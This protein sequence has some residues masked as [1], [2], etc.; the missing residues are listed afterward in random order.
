MRPLTIRATVSA[1]ARRSCEIAW[2]A[3][4]STKARAEG[5][6]GGQFDTY[7]LLA[8]PGTTDSTVWLTL[9]VEGVGRFTVSNLP[10]T[11]KA[12]KRLTI[13]MND[14]LSQVEA[15]ESPALTPGTLKGKSFATRVNVVAGDPIVAEEALYWQ[16]AGA[17]FWRAGAAFFGIPLP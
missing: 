14:F 1:P 5:S 6:S 11:V 9:F 12:G 3:G 8:N 13:Y 15:G 4:S 2:Y 7:I 16:R 17:D 10:Q